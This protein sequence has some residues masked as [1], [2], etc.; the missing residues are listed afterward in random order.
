M[1]MEVL[2]RMK[3]A[4]VI[5]LMLCFQTSVSSAQVRTGDQ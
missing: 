5:V 3:A 1:R 4:G 2:S